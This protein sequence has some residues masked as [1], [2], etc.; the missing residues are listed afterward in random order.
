MAVTAE[1]L[2][3]KSVLVQPALAVAVGMDPARLREDE[4][5]HEGL[6]RGDP[7][8]GN[9]FHIPAHVHQAALIQGV[10]HL[11]VVVE[12]ADGA[13]HG[14][15]A[16]PLPQPVHGRVQAL[17]AGADRLEGVRRGEV[18]VVVR[19]EVKMDG[20]IALHH[21]PAIRRGPGRV[22]DAEGVRE[23]DPPDGRVLQGV[24]QE[25]HVVRRVRHPVGPVLE[26]HIDLQALGNGDPDVPEDVAQ[27][28]FRRL[29]ELGGHVAE[30]S[31]REEVHHLAAGRTDPVDGQAAVH[32]AERLHGAELPA[33]GGPGA[34]LGES[35]LLAAGNPRR[36]HLDPVDLQFIQEQ[37]RDGQLLVRVERDAGGLL[38]V[39]QGGVQDFDRSR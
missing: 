35:L 28:L 36:G 17:D 13:G 11:Q 25:E 23:H 27:M 12:D 1:A 6:V 14:Q 39:T 16:G 15:V 22:Q 34:D 29:P 8:A 10:L 19:M 18:V 24:H 21:R 5:A 33:G 2:R 7:H 31:L 37:A 3:Q 32:E 20:R 30:G 4:L 26:V 38:A 9:R